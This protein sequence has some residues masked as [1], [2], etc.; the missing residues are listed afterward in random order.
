MRPCRAQGG[1]AIASV[2]VRYCAQCRIPAM[3]CENDA[4]EVAARG[5]DADETA[6]AK[7]SNQASTAAQRHGPRRELLSCTRPLSVCDPM[8]LG[9]TPQWGVAS[10]VSYARAARDT[11]PTAESHGLAH[12][13]QTPEPETA[14]LFAP[15]SATQPIA[16]LIA[17]FPTHRSQAAA[18]IARRWGISRQ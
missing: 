7:P 15:C 8:T 17:S 14:V 10:S 4:Q 12:T 1:A 16:R 9:P 13:D 11:T 2:A 5:A 18:E 6:A 3:G